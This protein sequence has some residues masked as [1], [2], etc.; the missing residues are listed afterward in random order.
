MIVIAVN[1]PIS[2]LACFNICQNIHGMIVQ[3]VGKCRSVA[4]SKYNYNFKQLLTTNDF[5]LSANCDWP[6]AH[7]QKIKN[8]NT[9]HG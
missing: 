8:L 5:G 3:T 2:C 9:N 7:C 6:M 1:D 4:S